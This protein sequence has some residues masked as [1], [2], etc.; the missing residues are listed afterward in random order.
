MGGLQFKRA[1]GRRTNVSVGVIPLRLLCTNWLLGASLGCYQ[2]FISADD[3]SRLCIGHIKAGHSLSGLPSHDNI[4][5]C[6]KK[7]DV[8]FNNNPRVI[9]A[10][11][12]GKGYDARLREIMEKE[13]LPIVEEFD[14]KVNYASGCIP[15]CGFQSA[16]AIYNCITCR[17]DSC[18]FPLDCPVKEMNATEGGASQMQCEVA[19][20]L[21]D[22]I[23]A[24]WRFADEIKTL[25]LDHF[26]EVTAGTDTLFS[27][28]TVS[29]EHQGTYQCEIYSDQRSI[30]RLYYFLS[31][32]PRVVVGHTELQE[33]F[34]L[35]LLPGG[36]LLPPSVPEP[37]VLSPL[38]LAA[39]LT[40]VF[41]LLFLALGA[42]VLL[43]MPEK[44]NTKKNSEGEGSTQNLED[45]ST[46]SGGRSLSQLLG[47][48]GS[49]PRQA[50]STS[51]R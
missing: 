38:L 28:T 18:E 40:S 14:G 1:E 45:P 24:V 51:Q 12:V 27:I 32:V 7:L 50:V 2:C 19:F 4:D 13:I 15:P 5:S 20:Q 26:E 31:V 42:L 41:L 34:E 46:T 44:T 23:M 49:T 36:R 35:S 16:G 11:R 22:G 21:P 48:T 33:I 9:S 29:L 17:Y 39:C 8:V 47:L 10:A 37:S 30:V 43:L 6:F 25:N 3:S